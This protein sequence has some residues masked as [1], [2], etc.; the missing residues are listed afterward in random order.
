[1]NI[2]QQYDK[3]ALSQTII[4]ILLYYLVELAFKYIKN[5]LSFSNVVIRFFLSSCNDNI[6]NYHF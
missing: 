5:S 4:H 1:M 6:S 2:L 3:W